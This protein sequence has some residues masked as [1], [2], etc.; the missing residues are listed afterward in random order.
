MVNGFIY[1]KFGNRGL[2]PC[3]SNTKRI[4]IRSEYISSKVE[5]EIPQRGW[6]FLFLVPLYNFVMGSPEIVQRNL[7]AI[8]FSKAQSTFKLQSFSS[9]TVILTLSYC[10]WLL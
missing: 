4:R 8:I 1:F 10:K 3:F 2:R 9:P 6:T 5:P 7:I